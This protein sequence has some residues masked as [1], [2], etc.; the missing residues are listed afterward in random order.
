MTMIFTT[1]GLGGFTDRVEYQVMQQSG[2]LTTPAASGEGDPQSM[3]QFQQ[4]YSLGLQPNQRLSLDAVPGTTGTKR[5]GK[6]PKPKMLPVELEN[7]GPESNA[8]YSAALAD[9]TMLFSPLASGFLPSSFWQNTDFTFM[10][11][12]LKFFQRK[13]N[14]N[15]RFPHKLFNALTIVSQNAAMFN[16]FG[17]R[18][19]SD[20]VFL[21]DKFIFG[22]LLGIMSIDGGLFHQQGNF[23]S[24]G[25]IETS[26]DESRALCDD[27]GLT[28][29]DYDRVRLMKHGSVGFTR[30]SNEESIGQECRW[31]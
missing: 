28:D 31:K 21:V 16:L 22:R 10:E 7:D 1:S 23:R 15:C 17:V 13:N 30:E 2:G 20:T 6:D 12:V 9:S 24:H 14:A 26:V 4:G 25:F 8:M 5:K 29:V 19:I 18:W 27:F 11:L 3:G